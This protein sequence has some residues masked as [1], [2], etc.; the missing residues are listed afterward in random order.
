MA[1]TSIDPKQYQHILDMAERRKKLEASIKED[2]EKAAT[3]SGKAYDTH[4]KLIQQ[5][6]EE[7]KI[8]NKELLIIN[9]K[10]FRY[11]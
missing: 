8:L 1:N 5:K 11:F 6:G 3:L 7:L 2:M 4:K 9:F 10:F